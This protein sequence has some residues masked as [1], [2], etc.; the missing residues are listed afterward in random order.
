MVLWGWGGLWRMRQNIFLLSQQPGLPP[1]EEGVSLPPAWAV[2]SGGR[3]WA[4]LCIQLGHSYRVKL[5]LNAVLSTFCQAGTCSL[6]VCNCTSTLGVVCAKGW[7]RKSWKTKGKDESPLSR[8]LVYLVFLPSNLWLA[9]SGQ[10][11]LPVQHGWSKARVLLCLVLPA[12]LL[13][14]SS[15]RKLCKSSQNQEDDKCT[16]E[17]P[18]LRYKISRG[19]FKIVRF[20]SNFPFIAWST[21]GAL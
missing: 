18:A 2:C 21:F 5:S 20:Y 16:F 13:S 1:I 10:K 3:G 17:V 15:I 4:E 7:K 6:W 11:C 14:L 12:Y 8:V 9:R 19:Y